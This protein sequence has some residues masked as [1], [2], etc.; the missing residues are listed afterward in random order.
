MQNIPFHIAYLLIRHEC[1]IVPGLGA[2]VVSTSDKEVTSR[3][4]ILSPPENFLG[5]NPEIKHND[6]LLANSLA[7]EKNLSYKEANLIINQYVKNILHS[8]YKGEN[9]QI[10]GVGTLYLRNT[11][12]MF[13][14]DKT[15]S[16]NAFNYGLTGFS[17][18][19]LKDLHR[20]KDLFPLQKDKEVV[21]IPI[22]RKFIS[23]LGSVAAAFIAMC[24][25][26]TPLNNGRLSTVKT[27]YASLISLATQDKIAE[28]ENTPETEMQLPADSSVSEEDIPILRPKTINVVRVDHLNYYIIIASLQTPFSARKALA[29]L[30]SE[31]FENATILCTDERYHIYM[32]HF[33]DKK[34]AEKF[35]IQFRNDYPK[36]AN[37]WMLSSLPPNQFEY[38]PP[39]EAT[40]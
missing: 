28:D 16:C 38:N 13:R 2:F 19:Y 11:K 39:N 23:Y 33:E 26:P 12:K 5:F 22:N 20:Q 32:N 18:P 21:W 17:L 8:L 15:L 25:V 1:V 40:Q 10:K 27:Q 6:G 24:I 9:V 3:W 14:P 30:Q 34:A 37:A 36:Y 29:E 7:K 4:G 31:G 35:L